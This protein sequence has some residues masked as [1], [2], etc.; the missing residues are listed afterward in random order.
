MLHE[1]W[2]LVV[3]AKSPEAL[4]KVPWWHPMSDPTPTLFGY[5]CAYYNPNR[6]EHSPATI[7]RDCAVVYGVEQPDGQTFVCE[8]G[9]EQIVTVLLLPMTPGK[10]AELYERE[11]WPGIVRAARY[12]YD[13]NRTTE[14][15]LAA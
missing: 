3:K 8:V 2:S 11:Q 1:P 9:R 6:R 5:R 4:P 14:Q 15:A 13:V 7:H 10:A 12:R